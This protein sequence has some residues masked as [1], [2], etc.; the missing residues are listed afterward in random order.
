MRLRHGVVMSHH[1]GMKITAFKRSFHQDSHTQGL[2][3]WREGINCWDEHCRSTWR[4][5]MWKVLRD[6]VKLWLRWFHQSTNSLSWMV[7]HRLNLHLGAS[8]MFLV[9]WRMSG[10][11][12]NNCQKRPWFVRSWTGDHKARLLVLRLMWMSS[13]ERLYYDSFEAKRKTWMLVNDVFTGVR[14]TIVFI[15]YVGKVLQL[16]WLCNAIRTVVRWHGTG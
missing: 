15:P 16:W 1:N 4:T 13:W 7:T 12:H 11:N 5:T 2:Q 6:Y 8:H 9:C 10:H 3:L 14:Q